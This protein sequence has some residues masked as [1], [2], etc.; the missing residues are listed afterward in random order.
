M[1]AFRFYGSA[2]CRFVGAVRRHEN[3]CTFSISM[4]NRCS[5]LTSCNFF[6]EWRAL[7]LSTDANPGSAAVE[8]CRNPLLSIPNRFARR[9]GLAPAAL[10]DH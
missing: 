5:N 3:V 8:S 1:L 4:L 7:I 10:L 9:F 2:T 6:G